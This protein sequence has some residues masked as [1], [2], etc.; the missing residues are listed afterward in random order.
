MTSTPLPPERYATFLWVR[1]GVP[2]LGMAVALAFSRVDSN[3]QGWWL[4]AATAAFFVAWPTFKS[5]E[6]YLR[7]RGSIVRWDGVWVKLFRPLARWMGHEE[8]WILSF[9]G[10]NNFR[11][12]Q[13]FAGRKAQR[14]LVLLPH[15]IQMARCKAEIFE[16]LKNCYECGLCPVEDVLQGTLQR[17]WEARITNRSHKAYREARAYRPD[18]IVAVSCTDRLLKGLL[19]VAEVPAYVL[20]LTLPH[21]MC[22]DTRFDVAHLVSAMDLLAEPRREPR[23]QPLGATGVAS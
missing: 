11:V 1:R 3:H 14:S 9:C 5:G 17:H 19:K 7:Q 15:C 20:P 12:R 23:I 10:W 8:A 4:L 18:L 2:L 22:V 6:A 21:G 13:A 16:D